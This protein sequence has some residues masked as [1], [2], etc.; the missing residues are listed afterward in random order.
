MPGDYEGDGITD[1]AVVRLSSGRWYLHGSTGV[2]MLTDFGLAG[3]KPI[4]AA[5]LPQ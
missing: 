3:D 2:Y 5:Y 1:E 4:P